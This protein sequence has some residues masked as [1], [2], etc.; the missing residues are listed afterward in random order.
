MKGLDVLHV[1]ALG[2][3]ISLQ[4]CYMGKVRL[5]YASPSSRGRMNL[6]QSLNAGAH[7]HIHEL[8]GGSWSADWRGF[9]EKTSERIFP[10]VHDI[11]VRLDHRILKS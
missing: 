8:L 4:T 5:S 9:Q 10:I 6:S 7:G 3:S 1:Y 2:R 11:V